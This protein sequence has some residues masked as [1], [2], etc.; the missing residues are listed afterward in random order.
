M[1]NNIL[2]REYNLLSPP[3]NWVFKT[4]FS[5]WKLQRVNVQ[6]LLYLGHQGGINRTI[7]QVFPVQLPDG[8]VLDGRLDGGDDPEHPVPGP[9]LRVGAQPVQPGLPH[10]R[11]LRGHDAEL[12]AV[13]AVLGQ[14]RT[15]TNGQ[16]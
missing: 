10:H 12:G 13:G 15:E 3:V 7:N 14:A 1:A 4:I 2:P 5:T 9:A 6:V 8:A 16:T 11:R